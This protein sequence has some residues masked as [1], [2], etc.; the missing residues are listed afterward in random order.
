MARPTSYLVLLY[1]ALSLL[2]FA[3]NIFNYELNIWLGLDWVRGEKWNHFSGWSEFSKSLPFY[4]AKFSKNFSTPIF[5]FSFSSSLTISLCI[6]LSSSLLAHLHV[7]LWATFSRS[8]ICTYYSNIGSDMLFN[9]SLLQLFSL[10]FLSDRKTPLPKLEL[11]LS[12]SVRWP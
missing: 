6:L 4:S 2:I 12:L 9:V 3:I 11:R 10:N 1:W 5:H 7:W 8:L